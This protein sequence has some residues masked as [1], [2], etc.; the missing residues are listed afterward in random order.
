VQV[1]E[2]D[3]LFERFERSAFRIEAR[4]HYDVENER[5]QFSAF[6]EG[7]PLPPRSAEI[8]PW[9][10]L[11][12]AHTAAGRLIER[13]RIVAQPLTDYTRYEFA[14]YRDN[15]A[16]G[17]RVRVLP[18]AALAADDQRWASEDFWI[19]DDQLVALLSYDDEGRFLGALQ[20]EDTTP[21]LDAKQR[22]LSIAIDFEDFVTELEP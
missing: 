5:D 18:R 4:D 8:D 16:A 14:A 20:A 17:E 22:A 6:L 12:A 13:V 11:V 2:F 21:Y 15:I 3:A 19:F 10:S 1:E 9:L 7:K